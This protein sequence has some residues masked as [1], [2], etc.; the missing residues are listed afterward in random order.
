[1]FYEKTKSNNELILLTNI[2][3]LVKAGFICATDIVLLN[4]F[5]FL[6]IELFGT[7]EKDISDYSC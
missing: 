7:E 5:H 2:D 6:T 3:C 4:F 1:M